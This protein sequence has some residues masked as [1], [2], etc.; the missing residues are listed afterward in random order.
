MR[1]LNATLLQLTT[2]AVLQLGG[3]SL[4]LDPDVLGA[5]GGHEEGEC[6]ELHGGGEEDLKTLPEERLSLNFIVAR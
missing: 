2:E 5:D 4:E 6:E 1:H 3:G